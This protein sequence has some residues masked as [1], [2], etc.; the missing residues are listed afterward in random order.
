MAKIEEGLPEADGSLPQEDL[1]YESSD[2]DK[3]APVR[4]ILIA[5]PLN[6]TLALIYTRITAHYHLPACH[7]TGCARAA[8]CSR[9]LKVRNLLGAIGRTPQGLDN[10]WT[11]N[12]QQVCLQ[13]GICHVYTHTIPILAYLG[14]S[15][16]FHT[17]LSAIYEYMCQGTL[18]AAGGHTGDVDAA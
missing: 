11:N 14:I 7:T 10:G 6:F 17:G 5:R 3:D 9:M 16:H 18:R 13:T 15:R 4:I 1:K 8:V 12:D 2:G